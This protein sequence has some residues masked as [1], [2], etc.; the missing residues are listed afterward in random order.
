[1]PLMQEQV[2]DLWVESAAAGEPPFI[3][4][5]AVQQFEYTS[6]W[7]WN[8]HY[9]PYLERFGDKSQK[10]LLLR[11][12]S[13]GHAKTSISHLVA[14]YL[15]QYKIPFI[16]N[17]R[18]ENKRIL[19]IGRDV[20]HAKDQMAELD[21]AI[22]EYAP[23]L[24][25]EDW[26]LRGDAESMKG[27]SQKGG[28]TWNMLQMKLTN[29]IEVRGFSIDQSVRR[30][31]CFLALI[32][33][34]VTEHNWAEA[35]E[36]V[37]LIESSVLKAIEFGGIVLMQGTP[38]DDTD[39]FA[40]LGKDPKWHY[41]QLRGK[42]EEYIQRNLAAIKTGELPLREGGAAY[43]TEDLRCLW[44]WRMDAQQHR[45]ERGATRESQLRYEREVML[46]RI[47]VA[48]SLVQVEDIYACLDPNLY[49]VNE[50][51]PGED[52]A[53]G[54]DPSALS[55]S[56]AAMCMGTQDEFGVNIVRHFTVIEALGESR[57]DDSTLRVVNRFNE[58][59][60][61]FRN[62]IIYVESNQFQEMI[63]PVS[64]V[65]VNADSNLIPYHLGGQKH[66]ESGWVGVRTIFA[67]RKVK[68]PYG[69][70][71]LERAQIKA[72]IRDKDDYE[73]KR[74]TDKF[75][76]QLTA[77]KRVKDRVETPKGRKDDMVSAF[78]LMLKAVAILAGGD[79][80][81]V[82]APLPTVVGQDGYRSK[83]PLQRR[84]GPDPELDPNPVAQDFQSRFQR[85]M[86]R[87]G[88]RGRLR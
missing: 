29:G 5:V 85:V 24:K 77:I 52:Y 41:L 11:E 60:T 14:L 66:T 21:A 79:G 67:N 28:R 7:F 48:S 40:V 87:T 26:Q 45:F 2:Y 54:G 3:G 6:P 15:A 53:G 16:R 78:F 9:F 56:D 80:G 86:Q 36:Q 64:K 23:W 10:M 51:Q 4:D 31:H 22:C 44:P 12:V 43:K 42:A 58:V 74:I 25:Y 70:T 37:E 35:D 34:L 65:H 50:A 8:E 68:L 73:A 59:S 19:V 69:P 84:D 27:V 49:Y 38:Q 47:T 20:Q 81:I 72:G 46:E 55:R 76:R 33:D 17:I 71:P 13:R 18:A 88:S 30:F 82:A 61:A 63:G 1:M 75:I 57:P 39:A 83:N 62:P 32:D